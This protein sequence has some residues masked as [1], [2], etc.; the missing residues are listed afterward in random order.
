MA[1]RY[2][3]GGHRGLIRWPNGRRMWW[4][5]LLAPAAPAW[6]QP[7]VESLMTDAPAALHA[8]HEDTVRVSRDGVCAERR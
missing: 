7:G 3:T 2:P 4:I 5:A 8:G 6:I 1:A